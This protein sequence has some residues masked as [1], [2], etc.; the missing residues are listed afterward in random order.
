VEESLFKKGLKTKL[1]FLILFL[2]YILAL[3]LAFGQEVP[4]K[5]SQ[6]RIYITSKRDILSLNEAGLVFDHIDYQG[7]YF[8]VVLNSWEVELLKKTFTFL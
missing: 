7:T 5:Y 8:D 2:S 4:V 3:V 1:T 6:V